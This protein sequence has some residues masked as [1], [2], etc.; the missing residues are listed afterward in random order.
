MCSH[1]C[2]F[3]VQVSSCSELTVVITTYR[4]LRAV[5]IKYVFCWDMA[6]RR[7]V[8][9][10]SCLGRTYCLI[11]ISFKVMNK[12]S[13]SS[14]RISVSKLHG[15]RSQITA[16]LTLNLFSERFVENVICSYL[17]QHCFAISYRRENQ[18]Q[19]ELRASTES[20][21]KTWIEAIREAR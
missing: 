6:P 21:C 18:R 16:I 14:V 11:W 2:A 15:V 10:Y 12:L 1:L 9:I 19:Y 5:D 8:D 17:L 4:F 13:G 20:D 7:F 3:K